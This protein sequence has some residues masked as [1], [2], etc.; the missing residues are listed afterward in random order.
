MR[1][2]YH[3]R[4]QAEDAQGIHIYEM[5]NSFK[6]LGHQ[7]DMVSLVELDQNRETKIRGGFWEKIASIVPSFVYE[8]MELGYNFFGVWNILL[9]VK[10]DRPD[11]IYER[12]SLNTFCGVLIGKL[13]AIPVI[14][15]VNAPLFFEHKK[16]G[17]LVFE[18][19]ALVT[20]RWICSNSYRTIVVSDVMK[21]ILVEEGVPGNKIIVMHNGINPDEF[22]PAISGAAIRRQYGIEESK[23]VFGFVGWFRPWHGLDIVLK[24]LK[25]DEF[26]AKGVHLMFVGDGPAYG[27]LYRYTQENDLFDCVTFTGAIGRDVI[28]EYLAAFDIAL[29][30]SATEYASPMKI[31][32]YLAMGKPLIAPNQRNICEILT[33]GYDSVMF[34]VDDK[35]GLIDCMK[36]LIDCK[37]LVSDM[38]MNAVKTVELRKYFWQE[39]AKKVVELISI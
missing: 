10:K 13:L 14:L 7:V 29:Q 33:N 1:I 20:E 37:S 11:F 8:M 9:Q 3:H 4:T 32:E 19:L 22:H 36:S 23:T 12:Y 30:P 25:A 15:E 38:G 18:R 26:N 27:D 24:A 16:Y 31:F 35:N 34:C 6:S 28:P 17:K 21:K 5:V 39:N 2:L